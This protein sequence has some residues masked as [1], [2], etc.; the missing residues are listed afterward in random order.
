VT[1]APFLSDEFHNYKQV[2]KALRADAYFALPHHAL[3]PGSKENT[4]G[5]IRQ[6]LPKGLDP[7]W[8]TQKGCTRIAERLNNRPRKRLEFRAPNE[9]YYDPSNSA[10]Q[11]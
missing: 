7:G 4:N 1:E 8:L 3:E 2:G 5:L 10:L 6:Y 11:T 9:F